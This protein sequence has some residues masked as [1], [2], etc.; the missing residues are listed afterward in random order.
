MTTAIES[1]KREVRN[2]LAA[3]VNGDVT[4]STC[5][6]FQIEKSGSHIQL[7]GAAAKLILDLLPD[8]AGNGIR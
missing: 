2:T 7:S 1:W 6:Q 3:V 8:H 5:G 4:R